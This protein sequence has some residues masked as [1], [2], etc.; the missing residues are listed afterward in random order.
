MPL[1]LRRAGCQ[2][3]WKK[4]KVSRGKP[5]WAWSGFA[6]FTHSHADF[7]DGSLACNSAVHCCCLFLLEQQNHKLPYNFHLFFSLLLSNVH[8]SESTRHSEGE[9]AAILKVDKEVPL[10]FSSAV[11]GKRRRD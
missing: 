4:K 10:S 7:F 6:K 3:L 8:A 2:H 11:V 9:A 1:L 5:T